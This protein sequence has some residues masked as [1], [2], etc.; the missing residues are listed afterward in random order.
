M[1]A[2]GLPFVEIPVRLRAVEFLRAV[3]AM[4]MGLP[5]IDA[6]YLLSYVRGKT[7]GRLVGLAGTPL[8]VSCH[9]VFRDHLREW[10]EAPMDLFGGSAAVAMVV[11][12]RSSQKN[13]PVEGGS[14]ADYVLTNRSLQHQR[15]RREEHG[16]QW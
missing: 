12:K 13:R 16:L 9:L 11:V 14:A 2:L 1:Q 8:A 6:A 10:K 15:Y 5:R 4:Y 3:W 7:Y